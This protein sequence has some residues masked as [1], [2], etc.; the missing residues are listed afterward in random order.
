MIRDFRIELAR[1]LSIVAGVLV[2]GFSLAARVT[3]QALFFRVAV[4]VCIFGVIGYLL[5]NIIEQQREIIRMEQEKERLRTKVKENIEQAVEKKEINGPEEFTPLDIQ[6]LS[7]IIVG[8]MN[9]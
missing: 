4:G 1:L 8:T 7:K 6:N 9:E 2:A 3:L 5:G